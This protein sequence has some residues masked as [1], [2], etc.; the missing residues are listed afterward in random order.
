MP[1]DRAARPETR[2]PG[3]QTDLGEL[4]DAVER[5]AASFTLLGEPLRGGGQTVIG[6]AGIINWVIRRAAYRGSHAGR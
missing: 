3:G 4:D 1:E 2:E 6:P 5:G